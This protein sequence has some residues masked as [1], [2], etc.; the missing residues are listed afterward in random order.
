MSDNNV[1]DFVNFRI[2]TDL[3]A[4]QKDNPEAKNIKQLTTIFNAMDKN[5]NH[6]IDEDEGT[7]FYFDN[8]EI[9]ATKCEKYTKEDGTQGEYYKNFMSGNEKGVSEYDKDGN[10]KKSIR[11]QED[12]SKFE[13]GYTNDRQIAYKKRTD[14]AGNEFLLSPTS[15]KT[16]ASIEK[17]GSIRTFHNI[18]DSFDGTMIR[19]GLDPSDPEI[20]SEFKKA[21]PEAFQN[22]A[23]PDRFTL[24]PND[25]SA[26]R[27]KIPKSILEK[28]DVVFYDN[29]IGLKPKSEG[30]PKTQPWEK[31]DGN[32]ARHDATT[33]YADQIANKNNWIEV[34]AQPAIPNPQNNS[35][36]GAITPVQQVKTNDTTSVA[37]P[38]VQVIKEAKE[39]TTPGGYIKTQEMYTRTQESDGTFTEVKA[40]II[41]NHGVALTT[42]YD[43][44]G[45]TLL[46]Q[47]KVQNI[48]GS[49]RGVVKFNYKNGNVTTGSTNLGQLNRIDVSIVIRNMKNNIPFT[50]GNGIIVKKSY[51]KNGNNQVI[52]SYHDGN[53]Y[54]AK[55][56]IINNDKASNIIAKQKKYEDLTY[57]QEY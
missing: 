7:L 32:A 11:E 48:A 13:F 35:A 22:D 14:K 17:D 34:E 42:K 38:L 1:N 55:N 39:G 56:K 43:T 53:Y 8:G 21:N 52:L 18:E 47:E 50:K 45:T 27:V 46:S 44:N 2:V 24:V 4:F 9:S 3:K 19:L 36:P 41:N 20:R 54:N 16:I 31:P 57:T 29:E 26:M 23:K 33:K 25:P 51:I 6:Q 10:L 5:G 15:N 28:Y 37:P 49:I 12:G 40:G 30:S